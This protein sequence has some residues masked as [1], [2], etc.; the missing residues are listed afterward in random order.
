MQLILTACLLLL[1]AM[2]WPQAKP[3]EPKGTD[4]SMAAKQVVPVA[5]N[6]KPEI[7]TSGF[8]DIVNNGQVNA[9]AR[10]IRLF[11]G[12]PGKFALPLSFYSGVSSNNFQQQV[13]GFQ[14]S[15]ES[16]V[17][18]FINPL[19]GLANLSVDGVIYFTRKK[20][21][22]T[23][24]G[25]LYHLGE[26][27]LTGVRT[28]LITDP[29]TGKPVNFL[30]GFGALGL[31]VQTGAWER[32]NNKNMGVTW[33]AWRYISCYT[34]PSQLKEFMPDIQT[35]GVYKGWSL[36]WGVEITRLVNIKVLY[37]KYTKPP[38]IDYSVPIYQFS[39]NYSLK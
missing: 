6:Y 37:Y 20:E 25:L 3:P 33:L 32:S 17:T 16:L 1:P 23:K 4:S 22:L 36:G 30:N 11:I 8:I 27:V 35:N 12:E 26:R 31:Y 29:L 10:F 2:L 19:S 7:F 15:N 28:G 38:E 5:N 39:F 21:K 9:S 18:N 13:P 14:Q 24:T 34:N